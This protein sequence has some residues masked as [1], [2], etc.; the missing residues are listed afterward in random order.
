MSPEQYSETPLAIDRRSDIWA[1]GVVLAEML[2]R[3]RPFPQRDHNALSH[4]IRTEEPV[5][6]KGKQ[7]AELNGIVKR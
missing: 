3:E 4:A 1:L 6:P 7:F 2:Q 5:L